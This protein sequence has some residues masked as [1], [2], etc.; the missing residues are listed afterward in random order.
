MLQSSRTSLQSVLGEIDDWDRFSH[1]VSL[2]F[3]AP[4]APVRALGESVH[5]IL[6]V[7]CGLFAVATPGKSPQWAAAGAIIGIAASLSGATSTVAVTAVRHGR[8][9]R[10]PAQALWNQRGDVNRSVA[11]VAR[12]AQLP[13]HDLS[14]LPPDPL[15]I[16]ALLESCDVALE[17]T[18]TSHLEAAVNALS[19][20][21]LVHVAPTAPLST[22]S[23]AD[24][25]ANHE[26][27]A[28]TVVY[29]VRGTDGDR[30]AD[31]VDHADRVILFQPFG[32]TDDGS[33]ALA[34]ACDDSPRRHTD[35]VV[36]HGKQEATSSTTQRMQLPPKV[37]RMHLLPDPSTAQLESLLTELRS[38]ARDHE[39]LR[40]FSVFADLSDQELAWVQTA[41]R[42]ERLDG[43]S[44]L[45]HQGKKAADA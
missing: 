8:I 36:V 34:V 33:A 42:W 20:W 16:T 13:D 14:T 18:I 15:I 35:L 27:G 6:V 4:D 19:G 43:G 24:E 17:T 9:A 40:E 41:L 2:E 23:L 26:L 28:Q 45:L 10:V 29:V 30:A 38:N 7:E 25:L 21:R 12:L 3:F 44:M 39:A 11:T 37:N 1:E 22:T 31:I 5:D 32:V